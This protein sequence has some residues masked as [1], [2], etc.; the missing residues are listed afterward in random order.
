MMLMKVFD[1]LMS[2]NAKAK[3]YHSSKC[4]KSGI[5][6]NASVTLRLTVATKVAPR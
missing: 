1:K 4:R 2:S 3:G 6:P 5:C